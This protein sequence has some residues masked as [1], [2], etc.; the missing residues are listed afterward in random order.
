MTIRRDQA[1]LQKR[2]LKAARLFSSGVSQAEV[3]RRLDVSRVSAM[4]WYQQWR[5]DGP[6]GLK[7]THALG[8]RPRLTDRQWDRVEAK[9][10]NGPRRCGYRTD[11]WTLGRV[12]EVIEVTTG[13]HYHPGHVWRLLRRRGWSLQ[14]PTTR[15]R[16]RDE[17]RIV[18]WMKKD[19]PKLKKTLAH[20][21]RSSSSTRR[22][23]TKAR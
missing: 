18:E 23:S 12:S 11:L 15:A 19:W 6:K 22:G 1:A 4:R 8:R 16:E 7:S 21:G 13:V 9:L 17:A 20:G 5:R 14:R 3:A 10:Q 2:R